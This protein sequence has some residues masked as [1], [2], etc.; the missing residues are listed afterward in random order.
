[1]GEK[2]DKLDSS[3]G[4]PKIENIVDADGNWD[5]IRY[6]KIINITSSFGILGL[7]TFAL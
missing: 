7:N 2:I 1:L 4:E 3:C 5:N 6:R